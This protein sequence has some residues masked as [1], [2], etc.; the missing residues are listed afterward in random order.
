MEAGFETADLAQ[1]EGKKIEE[2]G[3]LSLGRKADHLPFRVSGGLLVDVLQVRRLA[4]ETRAVVDDLAVD[5]SRS[6]VDERHPALPLIV[7]A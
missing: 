3:A 6:V 1:G 5:F 4:A 7:T 2:K